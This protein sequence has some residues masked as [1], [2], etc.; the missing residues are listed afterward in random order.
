M[1]RI[2]GLFD[3]LLNE[4]YMWRNAYILRQHFLI[5]TGWRATHWAT[6]PRHGPWEAH[7]HN[8]GAFTLW[9]QTGAESAPNWGQFL[10]IW[11]KSETGHCARWPTIRWSVPASSWPSS[12]LTAHGPHHLGPCRHQDQCRGV[13]AHPGGG[14]KALDWRQLCAGHLGLA[15]GWHQRPH[16][17]RHP[18]KVGHLLAQ[19]VV[20]IPGPG[21]PG[22]RH[23]EQDG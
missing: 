4:K 20:I 14:S 21:A 3:V 22:L 10:A 11:C 12:P 13:P 23:L 19:G 5:F 7:G 8:F 9:G 17:Q 16:R 6:G 1:L 18:K 15:A 2:V